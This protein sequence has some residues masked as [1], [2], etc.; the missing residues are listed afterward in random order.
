MEVIMQANYHTHSKWC[1]H[2]AGEIEDFVK[3]A[4][5]Q[6]FQELAITE[7]VPLESNPDT[8]RMQWEE[9]PAFNNS[10]EQAIKIFGDQIHLIKGF[11]CEYFP[12]VVDT[13][14]MLQEKYGYQFL[15]LGQHRS[16]KNKEYDTFAQKE[17]DGVKA[18]AESVCKGVESGLFRFLAHPDLG[19]LRYNNNEWDN[20]CEKAMREIFQCCEEY[21]MP[22]EINANGLRQGRRYPDPNAYKLSK[23]YHLQY[24]ISSDAHMPEFLYDDA[25]KEAEEFTKKLELPITTLLK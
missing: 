5:K 3:E 6:G 14:H 7:H 25:V 17:A 15:I 19:L 13:F 9:F 8:N 23:E 16:G 11:E 10:F 18:Y 12:D 4:I 22:I 24:L 1:H 2:G 21:S 20:V